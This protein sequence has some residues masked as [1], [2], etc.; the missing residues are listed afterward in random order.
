MMRS[1]PENFRILVTRSPTDSTTPV[2][3]P[4]SITSPDRDQV[5]QQDEEAP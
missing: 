3:W 4:T 1:S 5:L 2:C